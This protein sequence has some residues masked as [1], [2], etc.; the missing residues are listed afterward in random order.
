MG[1]SREKEVG[2]GLPL[3]GYVNQEVAGTGRAKSS[4]DRSPTDILVGVAP[5]GYP[6]QARRCRATAQKVGL[7]PVYKYAG[8]KRNPTY[9]LSFY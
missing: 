2:S 7:N 1:N 4:T 5:C 9:L 6:E 3:A 8:Q